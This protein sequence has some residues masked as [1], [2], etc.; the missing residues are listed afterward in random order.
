MFIEL[1]NLK[2]EILEPP[3]W[4][5]RPRLKVTPHRHISAP[6]GAILACW[7]AQRDLMYFTEP[8]RNH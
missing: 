6:Q 1:T 8:E 4:L 5:M 3:L 7:E 2:L